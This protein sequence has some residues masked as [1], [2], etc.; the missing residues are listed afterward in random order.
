MNR[1]IEILPLNIVKGV[2]MFFRRITTLLAGQIESN[3]SPFAKVDGE[4]GHF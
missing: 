1:N 3:H 4:L 2:H